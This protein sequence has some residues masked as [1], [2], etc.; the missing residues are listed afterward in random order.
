MSEKNPS[1]VAYKKSSF[2][3]AFLFL[4]PK[5]RR[6]LAV[7]YAFCRLMDD[8]ADEPQV[9]N[10]LEQLAQWRDEME[11]VFAG[12]PTTQ[13]GRE[14][15]PVVAQFAMGKDRF[16]E[17]IDGM[18]A[19]VQGRRYADSAALEVYL[20]QVA[21]VVG[22]A[23]LDIL[24]VKGNKAH[25]LARQLGFAVQLTNIVRDVWDDAALKRVYLPEDL[26]K[27][28]GLTQS[29]VFGA[30]PSEKLAA[31]LQELAAQAET[32]YRQA[33][34]TMSSLP[35]RKMLP[36]RIMA[37]V[38]QQNL[39]KIKRSGFYF[40]QTIKLTKWEKVQACIYAICKTPIY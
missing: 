22:L 10:R 21:G 24:G 29:D 19:D 7:Y 14:L 35:Q 13:L 23:T 39:A 18:Q 11:R 27:R 3:P 4:G 34:Q 33:A 17:L 25:M 1:A 26:L 31:A 9:E 2:G 30:K 20:W 8:M 40:H 32:Y 5:Q 28:H 12:K 16:S 36:C 38:Y 6:A 37:F 15:A